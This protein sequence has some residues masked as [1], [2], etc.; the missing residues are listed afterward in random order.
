MWCHKIHS[1]RYLPSSTWRQT[2]PNTWVVLKREGVNTLFWWKGNML[3]KLLPLPWSSNHGW[4]TVKPTTLRKHCGLT[5]TYDAG[6]YMKRCWWGLFSKVWLQAN[7]LDNCP[8]CRYKSCMKS[9][10]LCASKTIYLALYSLEFFL[11]WNIG[12]PTFLLWC[13]LCF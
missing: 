7:T 13:K 6:R 5:T 8:F 10:A 4:R 12:S 9:C 2:L 1:K 3:N 11:L